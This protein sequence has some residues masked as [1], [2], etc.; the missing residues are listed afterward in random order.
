ME[1]LNTFVPPTIDFFRQ[2]IDQDRESRQRPGASGAADILTAAAMASKP[3]AHADAIYGSVSTAD[4]VQTI[5][6]ALAHN[7]EAARVILNEADVVFVSGHEEGDTSR[8]KQLGV[9]K[10]EIRLPGA[11]E[12]LV[13]NIRVREKTSEA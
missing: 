5:R 1:L 13:R 9:F 7:D 6:G 11:E 8:V 3:K 10:I 12:P 2:R 4:V